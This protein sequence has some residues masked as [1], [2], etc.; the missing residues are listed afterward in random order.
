MVRVKVMVS[1]RTGK[2]LGVCGVVGSRALI[3]SSAAYDRVL[4]RRAPSFV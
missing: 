2:S 3:G 4:L 1:E